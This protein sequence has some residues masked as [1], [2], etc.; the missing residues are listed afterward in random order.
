MTVIETRSTTFRPS[1]TYVGTLEPWVEA[2]VGPQMVS[3]YV[4]TVLVRPGARPSRRRRRGHPR[5]PKRQRDQ[6]GSRHAGTSSRGSPGSDFAHEATR[7]NGLL[8][9][10][11]VSPNEAEQ[12]AAQSS[13]EQAQLLAT[14]SA[15]CSGLRCK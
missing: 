7:L 13:A 14:P 8:D 3:R 6:P 10:G 15:V 2:K 5:L 9:G 11:F 12:K 4:D 1:R